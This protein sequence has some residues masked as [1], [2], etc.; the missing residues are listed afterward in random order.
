MRHFFTLLSHELRML[1]VSP[2]TY[3]AATA[4]LVFMGFIFTGI[5]ESYSRAPQENSPAHVFFQ[6][7]WLPVFFMVPLLTMKCLAEERRRVVVLAIRQPL[8]CLEA[9]GQ[10]GLKPREANRPTGQVPRARAMK[11]RPCRRRPYGSP[12]HAVA[13]PGSERRP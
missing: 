10:H 7:F 6:L 8:R 4:F 2:S 5:L 3:I 13:C 11:L 9:G 1:L 12:G